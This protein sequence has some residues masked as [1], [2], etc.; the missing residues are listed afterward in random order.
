MDLFGHDHEWITVKARR[1]CVGCSAFQIGR[2]DIS[3][4]PAVPAV[5]PRTT[6]YAV[7]ADQVEVPASSSPP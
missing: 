7:K 4:V 2:S 3:W 6:A 1:W 5:C